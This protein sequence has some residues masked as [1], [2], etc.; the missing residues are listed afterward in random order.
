MTA[1]SA[2]TLGRCNRLYVQDGFAYR[3]DHS[4]HVLGEIKSRFL[5]FGLEDARYCT[6]YIMRCK[7]V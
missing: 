4:G 2:A 6:I 5:L 3:R 7:R 1:V